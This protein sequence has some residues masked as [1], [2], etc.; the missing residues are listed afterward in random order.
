MCDCGDINIKQLTW[1]VV[2]LTVLNCAV[3]VCAVMLMNWTNKFFESRRLDEV[4]EEELNKDVIVRST[5]GD[6]NIND[7]DL[8]NEF[9][10]CRK[11]KELVNGVQKMLNEVIDD[12]N[13]SI[14]KPIENLNDPKLYEEIDPSA[15]FAN[16][17]M[18]F[19]SRGT[20]DDCKEFFEAYKN[21]MRNSKSLT[22]EEKIEGINLTD[23]VTKL[24]EKFGPS[25]S[26]EKVALIISK[27]DKAIY[28]K[29]ILSIMLG[30]FDIE[31]V[32]QL[33]EEYK[34]V[35]NSLE[36]SDEHGKELA[37]L[38]NR[39]VEFVSKLI[40]KDNT[41]GNSF[42]NPQAVLD[43]LNKMVYK[44]NEAEKLQQTLDELKK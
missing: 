14:L 29:F 2:P 33:L 23:D 27:L 42:K 3:S 12:C 31:I 9:R 32:K 5:K 6:S 7:V 26:K 35:A 13:K 43:H 30:N 36:D 4:I 28:S 8:I 40:R 25:K 18:K 37:K 39:T 24:I 19:V 16:K 34:L 11:E 10:S 17:L 15:D 44:S 41:I 22:E 20:I 1:L 38:L 21:F